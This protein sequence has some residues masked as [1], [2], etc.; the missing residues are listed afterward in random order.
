MTGRSIFFAQETNYYYFFFKSINKVS[1]TSK[2]SVSV[3]IWTKA[4]NP[5]VKKRKPGCHW[6]VTLRRVATK[7]CEKTGE[8]LAAIQNSDCAQPNEERDAWLRLVQ[9]VSQNHGM[10]SSLCVLNLLYMLFQSRAFTKHLALVTQCTSLSCND[11]LFQFTYIRPVFPSSWKL[12][13][14]GELWEEVTAEELEG[15]EARGW[16]KWPWSWMLPQPETICQLP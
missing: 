9:P 13:G 3:K 15:T 1:T 16:W 12:K 5:F 14:S 8:F 6:A 2:H 7:Y 11:Q 10:L 4:H